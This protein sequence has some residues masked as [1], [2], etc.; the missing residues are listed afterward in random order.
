[1]VTKMEK[2]SNGKYATD[3]GFFKDYEECESGVVATPN[4][5][6][7]ELKEFMKSTMNDSR[8]ASFIEAKK[9]ETPENIDGWKIGVMEPFP[10]E[11][12]NAFL[13]DGFHTG[14][15]FHKE[16]VEK[17]D[18]KERKV[19]KPWLTVFDHNIAD[20]FPEKERYVILVDHKTGKRLMIVLPN[21]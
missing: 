9:A 2:E 6:E 20:Q 17:I 19:H 1:M 10:S 15:V 7:E 8:I 16:K 14:K 18:G 12:D 4:S 5:S 11:L 21:E 13:H 3:T